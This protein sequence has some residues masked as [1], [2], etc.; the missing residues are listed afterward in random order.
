MLAIA[1]PVVDPRANVL[2]IEPWTDHITDEIGHDARSPY[3][4][5]FWLGTLGPSATWLLRAFA[6]GLE[7]CPGGFELAAGDMARLL[8]LGDRTGRHSP[9]VRAIGRLCQFEL[10]YVRGVT[11]V[12]R[13][14]VPWLDRR[15]VIRLPATIQ[16]EHLAWDS[17]DH[18]VS[19]PRAMRRRAAG[20]ALGVVRSGGSVADAERSLGR[21]AF[22]PSLCHSMAEWAYLQH[23]IARDH[24][25]PRT[26]A[27][28]GPTAC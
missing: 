15:Q 5:R 2:W 24:A 25:R 20:L 18:E 27:D 16:A 23:Q 12:T 14:N 4:E 17:A 22:H 13:Q 3:V 11:I 10:V 1:E 28:S 7:S 26:H 19:P 8:G 6:Y 21:S 9:F